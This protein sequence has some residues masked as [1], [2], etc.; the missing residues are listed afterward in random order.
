MYKPVHNPDEGPARIIRKDRETARGPGPDVMGAGTLEGDRVVT[1]DGVYVGR[2]KEIILDV[3]SG[4]VAYAALSTGGLF[5]I[6]DR[7][8]AI[9]WDALT[10][11]AERRCFRLWAS[12]ERI[13]NAPGFDKDHWPVIAD[14]QWVGAA[15]YDG[16]GTL[17]WSCDDD[18]DSEQDAP[19]H[20][21]S[22]DRP[23]RDSG[24]R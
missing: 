1:A 9:P 17:W 22:P 24:P 4:R 19:P 5:G 13:R 18:F 3:D 20:E 12:S 7:L 2:I 6:G 14:P 10:L 15:R 8:L 11:D 21:A 23:E 16:S